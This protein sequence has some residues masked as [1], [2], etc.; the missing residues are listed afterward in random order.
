M[1][2]H[3]KVYRHHGWRKECP[4]S[5]NGSRQTHEIVAARSQ[6]EAARLFGCTLY[7]LI[8]WG[9]R[10]NEKDGAVALAEPGVIFW[11]PLTTALGTLHRGDRFVRAGEL[12]TE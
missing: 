10:M 7:E 1:T 2:R 6:V 9:A 4:A 11:K 8:G 12:W 3:L 5:P